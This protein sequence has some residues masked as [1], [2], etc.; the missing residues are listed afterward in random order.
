[1]GSIVRL[2]QMDREEK[3]MSGIKR[4][5]CFLDTPRLV[6]LHVGDH[7]RSHSHGPLSSFPVLPLGPKALDGLVS[8]Y[9]MPRQFFSS[10]ISPGF[11]QDVPCPRHLPITQTK[12]S[13][14]PS[15]RFHWIKTS[16]LCLRGRRLP[17]QCL[18]NTKVSLRSNQKIRKVRN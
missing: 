15:V 6:T 11:F 18:E 14:K 17:N 5:T 4:S 7:V 10:P 13:L 12:V 8:S 16:S 1:M 9:C 3:K 2:Q